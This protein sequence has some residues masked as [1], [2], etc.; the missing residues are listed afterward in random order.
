MRLEIKRQARS[1]VL[2]GALTGRQML[3]SF[4]SATAKDP[5]IPELVFLDFSGIEVATASFLR[6]CVIAFRD[7]I[8]RRKSNYYPVVANAS[9]TILEELTELM[10]RRSDVL[11]TCKLDKAGHVS[12]ALPLGN[13]DPKQQMTFDLVKERGETDA[14]EL[15]R[16]HGSTEGVQQTAWNN[17]LA[18]LSALGLVVELSQGR[19]KRYK[20]LF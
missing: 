15:M 8:R 5:G 4:L 19:A 2:A 14:A 11:M 1:A 7:V 13:L 9:P 18:S 6:E 3:A 20:S 17:R 16:D 10:H 12:D